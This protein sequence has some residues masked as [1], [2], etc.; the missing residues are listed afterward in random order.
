MREAIRANPVHDLIQCSIA[1]GGHDHVAALARGRS[2]KSHGVALP[3][4]QAHLD[5][6]KMPNAFHNRR[7]LVG[8]AGLW[9][10]DYNGVGHFSS[11]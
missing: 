10:E 3:G 6:G 8:R 9:I 11:E 2:G 1:T 4:R 5:I 7:D